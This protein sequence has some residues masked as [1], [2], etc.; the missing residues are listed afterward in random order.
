[1]RVV[2]AGYRVV[3]TH[4]ALAFD[5][6]ARDPGDEGRRKLRTLAG[7]YQLLALAPA[8]L[9]PWR[10]PV[11]LQFV[12]HK[13]GR[14]LVPYALLGTLVASLAL[15]AQP[16]Y[17]VALA[18]Q[19][20]FYGLAAYGWWLDHRAHRPGRSVAPTGAPARLAHVALMFLVMNASVI[21]GLGALLLG[22]RVWRS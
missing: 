17:A 14:L 10:N 13:L 7:N 6:P 16:L 2:M 1:M 18:A 11:W 22:K 15:A 12:S 5:R 3:F 21:A 19:A 9:L 8:L 4:H 20:V